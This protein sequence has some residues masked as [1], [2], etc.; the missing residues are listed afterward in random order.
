MQM[1]TKENSLASSQTRT[2]QKKKK[3]SKS[4]RKASTSYRKIFDLGQVWKL[5][6]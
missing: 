5:Q 2:S 6:M 3:K 1:V 4:Y